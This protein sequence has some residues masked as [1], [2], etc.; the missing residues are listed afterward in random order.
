MGKNIA[1]I[2]ENEYDRSHFPISSNANVVLF[3]LTIPGRLFSPQSEEKRDAGVNFIGEKV[4]YDSHDTLKCL[5]SVKELQKCDI[6]MVYAN[7]NFPASVA[8]DADVGGFSQYSFFICP[9]TILIT[10]GVYLIGIKTS[11]LSDE[12]KMGAT[13]WARLSSKMVALNVSKMKAMADG[14]VGYHPS[15]IDVS[16]MSQKLNRYRQVVIDKIMGSSYGTLEAYKALAKDSKV[17]MDKAKSMADAARTDTYFTENE[18]TGNCFDDDDVDEDFAD[19][20]VE[21][22]LAPHVT[23]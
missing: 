23:D 9:T 22:A 4:V 7:V 3:D 20:V 19:I 1:G 11:F 13:P 2:E 18:N 5:Y 16:D 17:K 12:D 8:K 10:M 21:E 14:F 6:F 15:P